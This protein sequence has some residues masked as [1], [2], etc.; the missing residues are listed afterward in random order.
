MQV[1][2]VREMFSSVHGADD[3]PAPKPNPDGMAVCL[4]EMGLEAQVG[5]IDGASADP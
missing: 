2:G 3:V 1:N 4:S 5:L